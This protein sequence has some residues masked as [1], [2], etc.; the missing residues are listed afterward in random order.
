V[1]HA[2]KA[3]AC[4]GAAKARRQA[5]RA[6]VLDKEDTDKG[7]G[8]SSWPLQERM[9]VLLPY[10]D[11]DTNVIPSSSRDVDS[12]MMDVSAGEALVSL[13]EHLE[14]S[15][16]SPMG[17]RTSPAPYDVQL[18]QS[19]QDGTDDAALK[20]DIYGNQVYRSPWG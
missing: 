2:R 1:R 7:G 17:S 10:G 12:V 5:A 4:K 16:A 6:D 14:P 13:G 18:Q 15:P 8:P 9:E 19:L 3:G 20:H 11:G